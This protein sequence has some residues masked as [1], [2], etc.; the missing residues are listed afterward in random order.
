MLRPGSIMH[1]VSDRDE[2]A[3]KRPVLLIPHR[4][5]G[6]SQYR[7]RMY[8]RDHFL[9]D[10]RFEPLTADFGHAEILSEQGLGGGRS[11]ED[12]YPGLDDIDLG[13][14]PRQTRVD[15]AGPRF[16]V[17]PPFSAGYP[18]EVLYGVGDVGAFAVDP[19]VAKGLVKQ[20]AGRAHKRQ[21][22]KVLFI[23]RL[24]ADEHHLSRR[25]PVAENG[26]GADLVKITTFTS[27]CRG[28]QRREIDRRGEKIKCASFRGIFHIVHLKIINANIEPLDTHSEK[29]LCALV[30][31]TIEFKPSLCF[32]SSAS[33]AANTDIRA[34][35][36][37][38]S[39][40]DSIM[41]RGKTALLQSRRAVDDLVFERVTR[42][43]KGDRL[44]GEPVIATSKTLLWTETEPEERFLV[45]GKIHNLRAAVRALNGLEIPA[46]EIFS[47]W[48]QVGRTSRFKGYVAGR[49]LREGCI[50]PN[51]GGGLCQ[52][53][54]ALYDAALKAGLTVI[55]RHPH[56]QIVA[57]SLAETGRDATV[58]WNYVDLR[59]RSEHG[60]RIEAKLD[61]KEL[62]VVF[63]GSKPQSNE[64]Q[65][66]GRQIVH[67]DARRSHVGNLRN[68]RLPSCHR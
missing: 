16:L 20:A 24:F 22:G 10:L 50:I 57:G 26:L 2:V 44:A 17:Q 55:E 29:K 47:F 3:D 35:R 33:M 9:S 15:L 65:K 8:G 62:T 25:G 58:F 39:R 66:I 42:H 53:S 56:T 48:K 38:P 54:N 1:F 49:E 31:Q 68:G 5:V 64:P 51:I 61:D 34:P 28:L 4:G 13:A 46:G 59:F 6:R 7:R 12:Q 30:R 60:F 45:A 27:P 11:E 14:E 37:I 52:I 41:F 67:N 18:F 63:K 19:G 21:S 32:I 23:A 43:P 36:E 40:L